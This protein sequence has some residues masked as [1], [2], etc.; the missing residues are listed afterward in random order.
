MTLNQDEK[1]RHL[2]HLVQALYP[3]LEQFNH[4]Q[5]LEM[6][7]EAKIKGMLLYVALASVIQYDRSLV[8]SCT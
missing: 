5:Q 4:E 1:I 7:M 3:F 2:K 8:L 6:E